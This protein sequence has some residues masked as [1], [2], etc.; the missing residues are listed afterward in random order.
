MPSGEAIN[1]NS[2]VFGLSRSWRE[3]TI[4]RTLGEHANHYTTD[5][6]VLAM[7]QHIEKYNFEQFDVNQV[8]NSDTYNG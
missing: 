6:V 2:I 7:N 5:A 3:P 1:I 4:Y 8:S